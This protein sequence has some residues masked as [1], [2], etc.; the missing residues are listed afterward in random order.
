LPVCLA[1][2]IR[3]RGASEDRSRSCQRSGTRP[4]TSANSTRSEGIS[5]CRVR[6]RSRRR[7][8]SAL[9]DAVLTLQFFYLGGQLVGLPDLALEGDEIFE[10]TVALDHHGGVVP[11]QLANLHVGYHALDLFF[12]GGNLLVALRAGSP[13]GRPAALLGVGGVV[14]PAEAVLP[15]SRAPAALS[16]RLDKA[17][18]SVQQPYPLLGRCVA[19]HGWVLVS[20]SSSTAVEPHG[21]T[22]PMTLFRTGP[23]IIVSTVRVVSNSLVC[24]T[25]MLTALFQESTARLLR[26]LGLPWVRRRG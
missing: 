8:R 25:F 19:E 15:R 10:S 14:G 11:I 16:T 4:R 13:G 6:P 20:R 17:T 23:R 5:Q 3:T 12:E 2:F 22:R 24:R 7:W 9:S 1:Q 21:I 26:R 18:L